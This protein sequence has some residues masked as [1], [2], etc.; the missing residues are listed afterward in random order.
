MSKP[1]ELPGNLPPTLSY[2]NPDQPSG[3][4]VRGIARS[5]V[6][7][8]MPVRCSHCGRDVF[9][10]SRGNPASALR[11][12]LGLDGVLIDGTTDAFVCCHCGKLELFFTVRAEVRL[13]PDFPPV[14]DQKPIECPR[15]NMLVRSHES[16]C[17]H[18]GLIRAVDP[19]E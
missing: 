7:E 18:C 12:M 13:Q 10:I 16:R 5:P 19:R 17:S 1:P 11:A 4:P 14:V 9:M 3:A 2:A 6:V 15:C 8:G